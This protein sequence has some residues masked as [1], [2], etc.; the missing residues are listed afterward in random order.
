MPFGSTSRLGLWQ[1]WR[2]QQSVGG[3]LCLLFLYGFLF[4]GYRVN[5]HAAGQEYHEQTG[6]LHGSGL[7]PKDRRNGQGHH[8]HVGEDIRRRSRFVVRAEIHAPASNN[9]LVPSIR[10]RPALQVRGRDIGKPCHSQEPEEHVTCRAGITSDE[11]P[12]VEAEDG[13]LRQR[14]RAYV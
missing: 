12:Q 4:G 5:A 13:D 7:Q 2:R 11:D 10:Q 14:G 3:V 1:L 6:L 9:A 8:H